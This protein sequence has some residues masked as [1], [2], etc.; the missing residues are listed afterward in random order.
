MSSRF[1]LVSTIALCTALA[2]GAALAAPVNGTGDLTSNVIY[3][4]GNGNGSFTGVT[5]GSL[6]LALRAHLR[7]DSNG[8]AQPIYNYDGDHTY[9]FHTTDGNAPSNRSIFNF[10]WSINT[11]T[12]D[13]ANAPSATISAYTYLLQVDTNP[14]AGV[15]YMSLDPYAAYYDHS[16]GFNSTAQSAG[17]EATD[18]T[19]FNSFKDLYNVSQQS[20]NMGFG[21]LANPQQAGTYTITLAAFSGEQQVGATS[22]DVN[23]LAP[24]PLPAGLPLLLSAVGG[25]VLLR[26]KRRAA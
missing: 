22:I 19:Q 16:F 2:G 1:G 21:F 3:G 24:V 20:W 26:R 25:L 9:T 8:V 11:D 6:E 13:T 4:S 5:T 17:V 14:G 7:Y 23:V 18:L 12:A 15:T 10:D